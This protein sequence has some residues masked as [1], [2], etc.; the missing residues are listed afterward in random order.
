MAEDLADFYEILDDFS[1]EHLTCT[2]TCSSKDDSWSLF[3]TRFDNHS[4]LL[5]IVVTDVVL[6]SETA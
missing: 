4:K 1:S 2:R 6:T 5:L 3:K